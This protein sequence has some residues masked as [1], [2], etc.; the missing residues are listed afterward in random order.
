[1]KENMFVL[2]V[3]NTAGLFEDVF[4]ESPKIFARSL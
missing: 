2:R 4:S 1:M 3:A